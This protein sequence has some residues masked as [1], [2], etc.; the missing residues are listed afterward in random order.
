MGLRFASLDVYPKTLQEFRQRTYTGAIVS[1][2]CAVLIVLLTCYEVLDFVQVRAACDSG[3]AR[4]GRYRPPNPD[5][6]RPTQV[7]KHD[8]LFVDTSRGQQLRININITFPSLPCSGPHPA[9]TRRA[10]AHPLTR[11]APPAPS[12]SNHAPSDP[13]PTPPRAS[14]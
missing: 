12:T 13:P 9:P 14:D 5:P 3:D 6:P 7:K 1:I 2:V 8:H 4:V 10:P 11:R